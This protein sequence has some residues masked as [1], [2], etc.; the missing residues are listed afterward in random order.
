[1][2]QR[3]TIALSSAG[4]DMSDRRSHVDC[5][6]SS[7]CRGKKCARMSMQIS[8]CA[9]HGRISI[10]C[11]TVKPATS[12]HMVREEPQASASSYVCSSTHHHHHQNRQQSSHKH[13]DQLHIQLKL[14]AV[15]CHN[16]DSASNLTPQNHPVSGSSALHSHQHW[17]DA[18]AHKQ[19]VVTTLQST[20]TSKSVRSHF[21]LLH[22]RRH[23]GQLCPSAPQDHQTPIK[24]RTLTMVGATGQPV[25]HCGY[26]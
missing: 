4:R 26:R 16:V 1:M 3:R 20:R 22:P 12:C 5:C 14:L 13:H 7:L 10:P 17:Q 23:S 11:A 2:C 24:R 15:L 18:A 6:I 25:K 9:A 19:R 8:C 21:S